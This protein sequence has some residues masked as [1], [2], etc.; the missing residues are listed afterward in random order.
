MAPGPGT[1]LW[2]RQREI[3]SLHLGRGWRERWA[4]QARREPCWARGEEGDPLGPGIL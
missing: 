3:L 2:S 1:I 4:S